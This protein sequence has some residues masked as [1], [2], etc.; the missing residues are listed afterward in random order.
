M[1][2]PI[3][4]I[5]T[6]ADEE[7]LLELHWGRSKSATVDQYDSNNAILDSATRQLNEYFNGKRRSFDIPLRPQG[8]EFQKRA[9]QELRKIPF[10]EY[11]SYGEQARRIGSPKA[12]RAVG[13]ANGKNPIG[14]FIPCHRVIGTNGSLTGFAGGIPIN[15]IL[16][17]LDGVLLNS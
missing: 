9:W 2:S 11:I 16:L 8:T 4:L 6:V 5:T 14:I 1:N 13:G 15:Q 12:V 7:A 17:A 3:G 10:G